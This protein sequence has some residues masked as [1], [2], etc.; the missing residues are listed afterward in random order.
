MS[1]EAN[2]TFQDHWHYG[3]AKIF[4][5]PVYDNDDVTPLDLSAL[6]LQWRL[7]KNGVALVTKGSGGSGITVEGDSNEKALVVFDVADY[8]DPVV[9]GAF[10]HELWDRG[11]NR[12]LTFG[13]AL[14]QHGSAA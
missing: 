5:I 8:G 1:R 9:P 13:T 6:T 4:E 10:R 12:V 7:L 14:L 11:N 2:I 3:E